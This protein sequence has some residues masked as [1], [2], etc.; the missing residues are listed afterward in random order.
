MTKSIATAAIIAG[1]LT[2]GALGA[3]T[4]PEI[5][6]PS[7]IPDDAEGRFCYYAG[8]AY[9]E[10]AYILLTGPTEEVEGSARTAQRLLEC[11]MEGDRMRWIGRSTIQ[12]GQ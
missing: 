7:P 6:G 8:L 10:K 11:I 12:V 3:Q 5:I 4:T 2:A 1:L 9:S